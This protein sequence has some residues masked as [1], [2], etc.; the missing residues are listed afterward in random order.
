MRWMWG[1][2]TLKVSDLVRAET[3]LGHAIAEGMKFLDR[4]PLA[5]VVP[6]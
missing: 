4:E 3:F 1:E 6:P 2:V 5:R